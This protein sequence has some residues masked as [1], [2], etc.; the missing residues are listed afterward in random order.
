M[1]N[2]T[3]YEL[4]V[5]LH[6]LLMAELVRRLR[7]GNQPAEILAVAGR[8]LR[9]HYMG[10]ESD[11]D[12]RQLRRL[13]RLQLETLL[14]ALEN[15]DHPPSAATLAEVTRFLGVNGT[16]KDLGRGLDDNRAAAALTLMSRL[17]FAH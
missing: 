8:A 7:A 4:L 11:S 9:D 13:W 15:T 6:G 2:R 17:P 10:P 5:E 16:T 12:R 1:N 14:A 3:P